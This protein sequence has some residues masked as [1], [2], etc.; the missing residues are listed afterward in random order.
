MITVDI[1]IND[2]GKVTD[3]IMDGMLIMVIMAMILFVQGLQLFF[4]KCECYF[5]F[6]F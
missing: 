1:S 6:N 2:E 3:V 5:K 4:W